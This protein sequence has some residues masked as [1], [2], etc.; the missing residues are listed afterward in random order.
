MAHI[1][2]N[3]SSIGSSEKVPVS[4]ITK[5]AIKNIIKLGINIFI[6]FFFV[7]VL[8]IFLFFSYFQFYL[9]LFLI[10]LISMTFD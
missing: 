1:N 7:F 2:I 10:F 8:Y 9:L 4:I 5:K 3:I 6:I